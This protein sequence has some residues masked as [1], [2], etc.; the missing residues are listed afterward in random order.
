[1]P[2]FVR[3]MLLQCNVSDANL[4]P[5]TLLLL[6]SSSAVDLP[7]KTATSSG[8]SSR[9]AP[10]E[11][12]RLTTLSATKLTLLLR[13]SSTGLRYAGSQSLSNALLTILLSRTM[14]SAA[15]S[16]G[17]PSA[18]QVLTTTGP[19]SAP[20]TRSRAPSLRSLRRSSSSACSSSPSSSRAPV[21]RPATV[22]STL[23]TTR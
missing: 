20:R 8:S 3:M 7:P 18:A 19:T 10:T 11:N 5:I 14:P 13:N 22:A 21:P 16:N 1:M 6:P 4:Q 2:A 9:T 17:L 12:S 15:R 23:L